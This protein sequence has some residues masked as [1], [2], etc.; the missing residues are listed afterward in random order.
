METIKTFWFTLIL[1]VFVYIILAVYADV[2]N[3]VNL[4]RNFEIKLFFILLALSSTG[5]VL[6]FLKWNY[7]VKN[8]KV[9][10]N[11]KYSAFVFFSGL[12]M[13]ITPA[14]LGEVWR[15]FLIK[16]ISGEKL[17]KTIPVVIFDRISD[18][19]SL[20]FLSIFGIFYYQE[21]IYIILILFLFLFCLFLAFSSRKTISILNQIIKRRFG[22]YTEDFAEFQQ[23]F[24]ELAKFRILLISTI[25]G[26]LAWILECLA[27]YLTVR[28]FGGQLNLVLSTFIFSF[29][30][31]AGAV[32]MIPGGLGIAEVTISGLLQYFGMKT[33][34]AVGVSIV[35]RLATLWYGAFLGLVTYLTFRKFFKHF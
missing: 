9:N 19:L 27:M 17:S 6:R 31:L 4:I 22:K 26:I 34:E 14:K 32:S 11:L 28:E 3:F 24:L 2:K 23:K 8:A 18:V 5:Y 35:I 25:L 15:S 30:S 10:I 1:A 21:A 20:I 7:L 29:A 33:T 12:S 13:T 16:E